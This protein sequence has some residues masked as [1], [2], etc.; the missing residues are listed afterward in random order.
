MICC[1][2]AEMDRLCVEKLANSLLLLAFFALTRFILSHHPSSPELIRGSLT[3]N[4]PKMG[5]LW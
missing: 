5:S 2:V 3:L 1:L 4:L